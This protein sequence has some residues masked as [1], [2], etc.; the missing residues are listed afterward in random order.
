MC[1]NC[2]SR[3]QNHPY[4]FCSKKCG[5]DYARARRAEARAA[6][7]APS[8]P[9]SNQRFTGRSSRPSSDL[10]PAGYI[11][12][13]V[14]PVEPQHSRAPMECLMC[15]TAPKMQGSQFCS[16]SCKKSA[17]KEAPLLLEVYSWDPKYYDIAKQ[18]GTS[19]KEEIQIP[20]VIRIYK[21]VNS[22]K[23]EEAYEG[24][25]KAVEK[26]GKFSTRGMAPGNERR[27]WH[28]TV[29]K[30]NIG[31]SPQILTPCNQPECSVCSI[32]RTSYEVKR[33]TVGWFGKGIYTTAT[34]SGSNEYVGRTPPGSNYRAMFLNRVVVGNAYIVN[35][36]QESLKGPPKGFDSVVA[37]VNQSEGLAYDELIV[38][39]NE[40]IRA[41]WLVIYG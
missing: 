30:C 3:P 11:R 27:R 29:R 33:S 39:K 19:W 12:S 4:E 17:H 41:S 25:K 32:L 8:S 13:P 21:I 6:S 26:Q 34:S 20:P 22:K 31:D 1:K 2:I 35:Q 9:V 16:D 40:A 14:P 37:N 5:Q 28:G 23:V 10:L 24:Y 15:R 7:P 38:Y 18:F 36:Q